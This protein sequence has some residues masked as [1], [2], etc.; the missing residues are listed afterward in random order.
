MDLTEQYVAQICVLLKA[1]AIAQLV[2]VLA[3]HLVPKSIGVCV[4][5]VGWGPFEHNTQKAET[6]RSLQDLYKFMARRA[7]VKK[8]DKAK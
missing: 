5:G 1:E 3:Y 4:Y 2:R 7:R 8:L 6:R